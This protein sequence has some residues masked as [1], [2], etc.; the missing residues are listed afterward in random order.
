MN[1]ITANNVSD[2]YRLHH[3]KLFFISF[4]IA[5]KIRLSLVFQKRI[6]TILTLPPKALLIRD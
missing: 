5:T 1:A 2:K 3:L 6:S 4:F